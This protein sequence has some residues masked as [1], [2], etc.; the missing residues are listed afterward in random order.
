MHGKHGDEEDRRHRY[1]WPAAPMHLK[2][3]A[4]PPNISTKIVS[5]PMRCGAGMP[6]ACKIAGN[7]SRPRA[8]L[9]KPCS[10]KP[11]PTIRRRGIGAQ[12]FVAL[13]MLSPS[14][15]RRLRFVMTDIESYSPRCGVM[16]PC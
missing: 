9:A 15:K 1:T 11:Y 10:M 7:A 13:D 3:T 12:H 2:A 14:F 4:R 5:H 8:S 16:R 6:R